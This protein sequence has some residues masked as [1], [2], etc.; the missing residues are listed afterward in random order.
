MFQS[1]LD[2]FPLAKARVPL[3][4]TTYLHPTLFSRSN[5]EGP[6][7]H[8]SHEVERPTCPLNLKAMEIAQSVDG[9]FPS[10][11]NLTDQKQFCSSPPMMF[12]TPSYDLDYD[13]L[14]LS[15]VKPNEE[16]EQ[17][18]VGLFFDS[19][20]IDSQALGGRAQGLGL[21]STRNWGHED[22]SDQGPNDSVSGPRSAHIE[23]LS[24]NGFDILKNPLD[25]ITVVVALESASSSTNGILKLDNK[26]SETLTPPSLTLYARLHQAIAWEITKANRQYSDHP[27]IPLPRQIPF[28]LALSPKQ[29]ADSYYCMSLKRKVRKPSLIHD[30]SQSP[31]CPLL[32]TTRP[33]T[34]II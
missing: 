11:E 1:S 14:L 26:L 10:F 33:P 13:T 2:K 6:C 28:L 8:S 7:S 31:T 4:P 19:S 3:P 22:S 23:L 21:F 34:S 16:L 15:R 17:V 12:T 30:R 9:S 5:L 25:L 24:M 18:G 32:L 20:H 27:P 29:T